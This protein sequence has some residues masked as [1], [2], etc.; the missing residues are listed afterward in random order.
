[1]TPEEKR[2]MTV[3]LATKV[4]EYEVIDYTDRRWTK[5]NPG[6]ELSAP[7]RVFISGWSGVIHKIKADRYA[8]DAWQPL[9]NMS[10]SWMLVEALIAK[11][12]MFEIGTRLD[13]DSTVIPAGDADAFYAQFYAT[14]VHPAQATFFT[15]PTAPL[16]ICRAALEAVK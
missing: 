11:G 1:M 2:A 8:P 10:D 15:G 6:L 12:L 3:E 9:D 4:L 14:S 16:A 7:S 13:F 5:P